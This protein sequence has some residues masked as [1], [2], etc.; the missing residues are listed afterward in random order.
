M[1]L[2]LVCVSRVLTHAASSE[3]TAAKSASAAF[4]DSLSFPVAEGVRE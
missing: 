2:P 4:R 1:Q 3:E